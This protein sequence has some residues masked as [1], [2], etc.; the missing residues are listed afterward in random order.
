VAAAADSRH[1]NVSPLLMPCALYCMVVYISTRQGGWLLAGVQ[2][3]GSKP[4][5]C[6]VIGQLSLSG[7]CSSVRAAAVLLIS[8]LARRHTDAE[9]HR[10]G[11]LEDVVW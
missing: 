9:T 3:V 1:K 6:M 2:E 10:S 7:V 5:G 11:W 4:V 8:T